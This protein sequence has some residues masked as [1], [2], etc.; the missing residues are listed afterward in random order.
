MFNHY[1]R[2]LQ[3]VQRWNIFPTI[4]TQHV[5]EHTFYVALYVTELMENYEPQLPY[6]SDRD[7]Y[8]IVRAA[9]IHDITESRMGDINGPTKRIIR[10]E[11][12]YMQLEHDITHALGFGAWTV[13]SIA[14]KLIKAADC[15]D[16][17][18][19]LTT[20][21]YLGNRMAE[22]TAAQVR[23]RLEKALDRL[24]DNTRT[25]VDVLARIDSQLYDM[26]NFETLQNDTDVMPPAVPK[27]F[28]TA[29]IDEEI[30]F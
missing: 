23:I 27:T 17:Y 11:Q 24:F 7:K 15:I 22:G 19:F 2:I 13:D 18:F 10:D 3:K 9:L 25:T 30:P 21:T 16:E 1:T 4:R 20:E 8:E 26:L 6:I 5:A 28:E 14:V 29:D 12:K